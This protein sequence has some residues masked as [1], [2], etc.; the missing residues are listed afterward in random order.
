MNNS[1]I[2]RRRFWIFDLDGTLTIP[3]H[4]FQAI[5]ASL[6][7]PPDADILAHLSKLSKQEAA[8]KQRV[9]DDIEAD[10]AAAAEPAVGAVDLIRE[11]ASRGATMGVLTRNSKLNAHTALANIGLDQY[12][13]DCH[14]LGRDEAPPKPDPLGI[15][16]L[17]GNWRAAAAAAL[18]VGD[19]LYDLQCARA[20]GVASVHVDSSGL[21]SWPEHTDLAVISLAR[22]HELY[23]SAG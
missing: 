12:F 7:M 21:F 18:M 13:D 5:K 8:E 10:L 3:Q 2:L 11:L 1:T 17:L 4:D 14:V 6:D 19:F 16:S 20:A 22:L 23:V 15:T 9:L